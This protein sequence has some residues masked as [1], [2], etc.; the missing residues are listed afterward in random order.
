[1]I[2]QWRNDTPQ[3]IDFILQFVM[4]LFI[5]SVFVQVPCN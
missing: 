5:Y 1:M 2:I 3:A 4:D